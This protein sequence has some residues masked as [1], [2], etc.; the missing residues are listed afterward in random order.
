MVKFP[1]ILVSVFLISCSLK[2]PNVEV[3]ITLPSYRAACKY[4]IS[5][6]ERIIP[7]DEWFDL[8]PGRFSLSAD[9]FAKYQ[10]FVKLACERQFCSDGEKKAI[11]QFIQS[12]KSIK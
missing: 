4:S 12:L 9:G 6:D 1:L 3:C 8:M 2:T 7:A 5:G 10:E 11:T